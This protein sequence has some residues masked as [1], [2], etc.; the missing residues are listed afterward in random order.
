M[1]P[2]RQRK[3]RR[4]LI[5]SLIFVALVILTGLVLTVTGHTED[6]FANMSDIVD[7]RQMLSE[8]N[9]TDQADVFSDSGD[10]AIVPANSIRN[11]GIDWSAFGEVLYDL[12]F[13]C[14]ATAAV[15]VLSYLAKWLAGVTGLRRRSS[16]APVK[17]SRR[18][19]PPTIGN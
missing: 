15:I 11:A 18:S 7:M 1:N 12:W 5:G 4:W 14:A 2:T 8:T 17:P 3:E 9:S 16:T 10:A 13:I 19:T 6:P